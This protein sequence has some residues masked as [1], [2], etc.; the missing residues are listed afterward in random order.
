MVANQGARRLRACI[1]GIIPGD[2]TEAAVIQCEI[3]LKAQADT[4]PEALQKMAAVFSAIGVTQEML[5]QRIQ[6]K[7]ESIVPAQ[8]I[9]LRKIFNSI[10]DGMSK[11]GIGLKWSRPNPGQ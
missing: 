11:P 5:E 9:A 8:V 2:V 3:T 1:L 4:S 7:L 10:K 6:R